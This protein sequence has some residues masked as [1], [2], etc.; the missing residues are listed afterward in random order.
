[1]LLVKEIMVLLNNQLAIRFFIVACI[2]LLT[3]CAGNK[4]LNHTLKFAPEQLQ[5]DFTV[6][7]NILEES[8]PS[9]YWYTTKDSLNQ[10]FD[11]GYAQLRDS[12]T[13]VEFRKI[14]NYTI[15][16]INCGHTTTSYSKHFKRH[17]D[18][19]QQKQFPLSI[20]L[21]KD[22]A[23]IYANLLS[24]DTV[25]QR[26]TVITTINSKPIAYY[27]DSLIQFIAS[28]GYNISHKYQTLSN[29][30]AFGSW[31]K[32]V[33]GL[34]DSFR[35]DYLDTLW[36]K[37]T[38]T[39]P[40]YDPKKDST[41]KKRKLP[42]LSAKER[43][44]LKLKPLNHLEIDTLGKSALLTMN[45]FVGGHRIGHFIKSA[46]RTL[47][48]QNI[49]HLIIDVRN[50]GGGDVKYSTLLSKYIATSQFKLADSLYAVNKRSKYGKYILNH[51]ANRLFMTIISRRH[52]DGHYHFGYYERHYFLPKRKNHFDG[53]VYVLTGGNSF[54][55]TTLFMN[56][57]TEEKNVLV[58][59]EETGGGSYGNTAWLIP[60][61]TLPITKLRFRLPKFRLVG[62]V[63]FPKT[64]RGIFPDIEVVPTVESI[65]KG[66]DLKLDYVRRLIYGANW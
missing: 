63:N 51:S 4:R 5:A 39:I 58:L 8:H 38:T 64:G 18:T 19:S 35:I 60:T 44:A 46:F 53:K 2:G 10:Y 26:G 59:G 27:R 40:V 30:N 17:L 32:N 22:T 13:E 50:N 25:L 34:T 24:N 33:F 29:R 45:T 11:N 56:S 20:K 16:K 12:M 9:L 1:M 49:E 21:L 61:A 31:Y 48:K 28:D 15:S 62:N 36:N 47:R 52:K 42:T 3:A 7:R 65:R 66:R 6:F 55:A 37:H 57:I 41:Y 43:K 23:V 54:S 14:L